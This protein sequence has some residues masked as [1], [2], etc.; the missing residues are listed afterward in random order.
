M[1]TDKFVS[2]HNGPREHEVKEML[3]KIFLALFVVEA[4]ECED[5]PRVDL[6]VDG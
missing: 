2:R 1:T 5:N 3:K 6:A 4:L